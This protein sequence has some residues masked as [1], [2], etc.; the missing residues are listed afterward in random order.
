MKLIFVDQCGTLHVVI[1]ANTRLPSG[2][3]LWPEM[4]TIPPTR[5][6]INWKLQLKKLEMSNKSKAKWGSI[7]HK[8]RP[9]PLHTLVAPTAAPPACAAV[10]GDANGAGW[11]P[12][13]VGNCVKQRTEEWCRG[14]G[15]SVHTGLSC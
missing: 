13:V 10:W 9:L 11:R 3:D 5:T 2:L 12:P 7:N 4:N 1:S 8:S 15:M 14:Q 6:A